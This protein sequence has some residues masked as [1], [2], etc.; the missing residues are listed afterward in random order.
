MLSSEFLFCFINIS[1]TT[2]LFVLQ[3]VKIDD[4]EKKDLKKIDREKM[5]S[6]IN[7]YDQLKY[8]L[9]PVPST[10][11]AAN[12]QHLVALPTVA[13]VKRHFKK[14]CTRELNL[15]ARKEWQQL[16][17]KTSD[18]SDD[19]QRAGVFDPSGELI[20]GIVCFVP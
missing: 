10:I 13:D 20:Y 7:L 18:A 11:T 2:F 17:A 5:V 6:I 9:E 14:L 8:N 19:D 4:F 12:M 3:E 16:N 15:L 1:I